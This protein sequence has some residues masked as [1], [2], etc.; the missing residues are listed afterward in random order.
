MPT[1]IEMLLGGEVGIESDNVQ[2][3]GPGNKIRISQCKLMEAFGGKSFY[4][5]E[6]EDSE[7]SPSEDDTSLD[8]FGLGGV[9]EGGS[10]LTWFLLLPPYQAGRDVFRRGTFQ[11]GRKR[12]IM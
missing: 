10:T 7:D 8:L 5:P 3:S 6:G 4:L 2:R 12:K 11:E 1:K 9:S